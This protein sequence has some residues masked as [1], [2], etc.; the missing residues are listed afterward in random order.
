MSRRP[1]VVEV[2]F[3]EATVSAHDVHVRGVAT[4]DN[5]VEV[6]VAVVREIGP[7]RVQVPQAWSGLRRDSVRWRQAEVARLDYHRSPA[8][9]PAALDACP[10]PGGSR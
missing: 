1:A 6:P 5:G 9:W 10:W 3:T 8:R 4:L 2:R 7:A